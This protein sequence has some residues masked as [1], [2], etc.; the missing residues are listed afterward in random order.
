MT[1]DTYMN[2]AVHAIDGKFDAGHAKDNPSLV[3]AFMIS[4]ALDYLKIRII[5]R[6]AEDIISV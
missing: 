1:A 4:A 2:E 5:A 6:Q 3:G